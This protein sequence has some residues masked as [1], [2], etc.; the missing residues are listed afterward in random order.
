MLELI[1]D[2]R[3]KFIAM[4]ENPLDSKDLMHGVPKEFKEIFDEITT[5]YNQ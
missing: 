5:N 2:P 4:E 1:Y 3:N